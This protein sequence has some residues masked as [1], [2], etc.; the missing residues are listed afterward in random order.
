M[1]TDRAQDSASDHLSA[2]DWPAGNRRRHDSI[3]A[4]RQELSLLRVTLGRRATVAR[5]AQAG[6]GGIRG[7]GTSSR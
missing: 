7:R 2:H 4:Q 5:V 6:K 3:L 1:A